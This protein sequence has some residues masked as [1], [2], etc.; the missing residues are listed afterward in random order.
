MPRK[1]SKEGRAEHVFGCVP[2]IITERKWFDVSVDTILR[3]I[4]DGERV[5]LH[6]VH[7]RPDEAGGEE[8]ALPIRLR[9]SGSPKYLESWDVCLLLY[10]RRID[11]F[12]Y[13]QR[14]DDPEGIEQSGWHRHVWDEKSQSADRS[15]VSVSMFDHADITFRDFVMWSLKAMNISCPKD[16]DYADGG[17]LFSD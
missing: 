5:D 1:P 11:G 12:G 15:K 2:D 8:I 14:F 10:N 17:N 4:D 7:H 9:I 16:D 13:E 3:K 6:G